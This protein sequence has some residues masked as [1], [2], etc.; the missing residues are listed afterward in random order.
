MKGLD[1][2][3]QKMCLYIVCRTTPILNI[4]GFRFCVILIDQL[5]NVKTFRARKLLTSAPSLQSPIKNTFTV[6]SFLRKYT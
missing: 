6:D 1:S 2:L 4:I 5:V 3:L